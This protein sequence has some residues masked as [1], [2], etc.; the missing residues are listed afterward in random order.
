MIALP[1]YITPHGGSNYY[2]EAEPF[3]TYYKTSGAYPSS[4]IVSAS[5]TIGHRV[6]GKMNYLEFALQFSRN[7][8]NGLVL[9]I[10][11]MKNDGSFVYND[12][13]L[14]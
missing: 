14:M 13:T 1:V 6:Y 11:V 10:P 2:L 5:V 3:H 12:P 7:D 8:I 4:G 9:E